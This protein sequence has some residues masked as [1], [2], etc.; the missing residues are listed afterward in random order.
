VI[1]AAAAGAQPV[2]SFAGRTRALL[3]ALARMSVIS[4]W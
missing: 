3:I 2:A 1:A 4:I